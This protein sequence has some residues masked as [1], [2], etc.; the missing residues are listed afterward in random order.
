[1]PTGSVA[2]TYVAFSVKKACMAAD[3]WAKFVAATSDCACVIACR[4]TV[5]VGPSDCMFFRDR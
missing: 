1:M 2:P 4:P 5:D 3:A